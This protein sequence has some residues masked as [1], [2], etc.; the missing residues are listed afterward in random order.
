MTSTASTP[1]GQSNVVPGYGSQA[2]MTNLDSFPR[3]SQ[4]INTVNSLF[5]DGVWGEQALDAVFL[6]ETMKDFLLNA[7]DFITNVT[8]NIE[9]SN[10]RGVKSIRY[11]FDGTVAGVTPELSSSM[12]VGTKKHASHAEAIRHGLAAETSADMLYTKEGQ[13]EWGMKLLHIASSANTAAK[14]DVIR[15]LLSCRHIYAFLESHLL[16]NY[17]I[18][19]NGIVDLETSLFGSLH[20]DPF[21][22]DNMVVRLKTQMIAHSHPTDHLIVPSGTMALMKNSEG[23]D[24]NRYDIGGQEAVQKQNIFNFVPST[25]VAEIQKTPTFELSTFGPMY[26]KP[27]A[28]PMAQP[29]QVGQKFILENWKQRVSLKVNERGQ[30]HPICGDTWFIDYGRSVMRRI[31]M[32]DC[33]DHS[34]VFDEYHGGYSMHVLREIQYLNDMYEKQ[35]D[36]TGIEFH[37]KKMFAFADFT[38][39]SIGDN[40]REFVVPATH[41]G[42]LQS[43][44]N[45]TDILPNILERFKQEFLVYKDVD[46]KSPS[47]TQAIQMLNEGVPGASV[48]TINNAAGANPQAEIIAGRSYLDFIRGLLPGELSNYQAIGGM[49]SNEWVSTLL[50]KPEADLSIFFNNTKAFDILSSLN[51]FVKTVV[52]LID[53]HLPNS[54]IFNENWNENEKFDAIYHILSPYK[55]ALF[56]NEINGLISLPPNRI[57][58]NDLKPIG[59]VPP[60]AAYSINLEDN[61]R[62]FAWVIYRNSQLTITTNAVAKRHNL[63]AYS[64]I[65]SMNVLNVFFPVPPKITDTTE[66]VLNPETFLIFEEV[67][68]RS[69]PNPSDAKLIEE[70]NKI[71]DKTRAMIVAQIKP[72]STLTWNAVPIVRNADLFAIP[73]S[74]DIYLTKSTSRILKLGESYQVGQPTVF[75]A[76]M[77][78][79][80]YEGPVTLESV[81][82]QSGYTT[83]TDRSRSVALYEASLLGT[84]PPQPQGTPKSRLRQWIREIGAM[85]EH[86]RQDDYYYNFNSKALAAKAREVHRSSNEPWAVILGYAFLLTPCDNKEIWRRLITDGF[87]VP[88][89]FIVFR[90]WVEFVMAS[91]ILMKKGRESIRLLLGRPNIMIGTDPVSKLIH[92]HATFTLTPVIIN[93]KKISVLPHVMFRSYQG[94]GGC[95]FIERPEDMYLEVQVRPSLYAVAVRYD[96]NYDIPHIALTGHFQDNPVYRYFGINL[97]E[98]DAD[99]TYS[100]SHMYTAINDWSALSQQN[101]DPT[102]LNFSDISERRWNTVCSQGLQVSWNSNEGN[103]TNLINSQGHLPNE[104]SVPGALKEVFAGTRR[105]YP[106]FD[107]QKLFAECNQ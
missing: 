55:P 51:N 6:A 95:N 31:K 97:Q 64:Q 94:G 83:L 47:I 107:L 75:R 48:G 68:Q 12:L 104:A 14:L 93:E 27:G 56:F 37:P 30:F 58:L 100:T 19:I 35:N 9:E 65:P 91:A 34:Q 81:T 11:E 70:F 72:P 46:P 17:T 74:I 49:F 76:Y 84:P 96:E 3:E 105:I 85:T 66:Q 45:F 1:T 102:S 69:G 43:H 36:K 63:I 41:F 99:K 52:Q 21:A 18:G 71:T 26:G 59:L 57:D 42:K 38:T 13:M 61:P 53:T 28:D 15:A 60:G 4:T 8:T 22:F 106:K 5:G 88:M 20:R 16:P 79:S 50:R 101:T 62:E 33:L 86:R 23:Y 2:V 82:R 10:A 73:N 89:S 29:T 80:L 54:S 98:E 92:A 90:P 39:T 77:D 25:P 40:A 24:R 87:P 78:W 67:A 7:D 32:T 44:Q 103:F